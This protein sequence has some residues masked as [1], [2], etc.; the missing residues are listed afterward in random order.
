MPKLAKQVELLH[1]N[2][3]ILSANLGSAMVWIMSQRI[4]I[5]LRGVFPSLSAVNLLLRL[6]QS[7][8][9]S[10]IVRRTAL[11]FPQILN[12]HEV[13]HNCYCFALIR[14]LTNGDVTLAV[15]VHVEQTFTVEFDPYELKDDHL[16][17]P[18]LRWDSRSR[19]VKFPSNLSV[20]LF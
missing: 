20:S 19:Q 16:R 8:L 14:N 2:C 12:R 1:P 18:S 5:H 7:W 13:S 11:I 4:L 15:Q 10:Q 6:T 9:L 3:C 17:K